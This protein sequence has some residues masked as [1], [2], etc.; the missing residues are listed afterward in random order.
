V[1][2]FKPNAWGLYDM[3]GNVKE[4]CGDWFGEYPKIE[5]KDPHGPLDRFQRVIRGS[6]WLSGPNACRSAARNDLPP[7][8]RSTDEGFRVVLEL[9]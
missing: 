7:D 1:G 3:V 2:K 6:S 4:W 5:V 8:E 9:E